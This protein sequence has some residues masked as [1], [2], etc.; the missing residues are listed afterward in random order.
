MADK[1]QGRRLLESLADPLHSRIVALTS[2]ELRAARAELDALSET[3]CGWFL[4]RCRSLLRD[5]IDEWLIDRVGDTSCLKCNG[6]ARIY[7][8]G[9]AV[10]AKCSARRQP[11][12]AELAALHAEADRKWCGR[13]SNDG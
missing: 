10:C 11:D 5:A 1:T 6:A 3:N 4:Y 13:E 9:F 8:D 12:V 2:A 7:S